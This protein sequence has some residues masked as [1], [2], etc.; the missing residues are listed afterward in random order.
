MQLIVTIELDAE[1]QAALN[2]LIADYREPIL[3]QAYLAEVLRGAIRGRVEAN[4]QAALNRIGAAA[5]AMP[6]ENRVALIQQIESQ[7]QP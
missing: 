6:F 3:P 2:D 5:R 7:I 1:Y 4:Y